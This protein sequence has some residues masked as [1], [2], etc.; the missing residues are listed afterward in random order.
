[1]KK[2]GLLLFSTLALSACKS[3]D[4]FSGETNENSPLFADVDL[5]YTGTVGTSPNDAQLKY[6]KNDS[7]V[8]VPTAALAVATSIDVQDNDVYVGGYLYDL[9]GTS[10][11]PLDGMIWKNGTTLH[12]LKVNEGDRVTVNDLKIVNNTLHSAGLINSTSVAYWENDVYHQWT[13]P[14]RYTRII[15]MDVSG[16]DVYILGDVQPV[17]SPKHII[18]YWKNGEEHSITSP[19]ELYFAA[20]IKII[21]NDVY[22]LGTK[23][24][25]GYQIVLW[26]NGVPTNIGD[27]Y[28]F[29]YAQS[30]FIENNNIYVGAYMQPKGGHLSPFIFKNGVSLPLEFDSEEG[31]TLEDIYV[32]NDDV[33]ALG[34]QD[35]E[36]FIWK[37]GARYVIREGNARVKLS[38]ITG[39]PK[40]K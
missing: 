39:V 37:N 23:V 13:E 31:C 32:N 24:D 22:I 20:D 33:Y 1:M 29:G 16:N 11:I 15:A 30:L 38:K 35:S 6:W 5:Y 18:T 21:G 26:K 36:A 9:Q 10:S 40:S 3:D 2:I 14:R 12:D 28:T 27:L 19:D 4:N 17:G 34:H 25:G 7:I 8:A